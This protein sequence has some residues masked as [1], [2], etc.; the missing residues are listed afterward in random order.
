MKFDIQ[1]FAPINELPSNLTIYE[2]YYKGSRMIGLV[3]IDLPEFSN[4]LT[5]INGAG[6]AG[7]F[8]MPSP[9]MLE[10]MEITLHFHTTQPGVVELFAHKAHELTLMEAI[11]N[12]DS[13]KGTFRAQPQKIMLRGVPHKLTPGKLERA[14]EMDTEV[15]LG[16]DYIKIST[17]GKET[18]EYDKFNF[19]Y[20][21]NGV[22]YLRRTR[23]AIGRS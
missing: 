4:I 19:V 2:A 15:T 7:D 13:G 9:G 18:I 22:D 17:D 21:V 11:N 20:R 23:T 12:Y 14:S 6:I 10:D 16:V 1:R 5:D 8:S 3:T